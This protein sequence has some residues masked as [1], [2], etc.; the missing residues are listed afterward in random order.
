[1]RDG[2]EKEIVY[3][4]RAPGGYRLLNIRFVLEVLYHN[5]EKKSRQTSGEFL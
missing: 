5:I 3:L 2:N 1:M 4:D